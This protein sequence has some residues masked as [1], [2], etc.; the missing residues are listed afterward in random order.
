MIYD[1]LVAPFADFERIHRFT[2]LDRPFTIEEGLL[3]PTMKLKRRAV[4]ERFAKEIEALY[5][6]AVAE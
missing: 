5:G 3:T 1:L 4:A 6:S 2:L